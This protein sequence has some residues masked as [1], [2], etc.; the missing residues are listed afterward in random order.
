[1]TFSLQNL[2]FHYPSSQTA[3]LKN[4]TLEIGPGIHGFTGRTGS[5]K[6]TICRVL[7]RLYPVEDASLLFEGLDVN[8]LALDT[9]RSHI[10]YVAQ[11]PVLFSNTIAANIRLGAPHSSFAQV[12]QAARLAAIHDD[13][14]GLPKQYETLI[15][16]RGIKLS[17]GQRQRLALARALLV[18]RSVLLIDDGLSAVDVETEHEIF[19]RLKEHF[20]DKTVV[21]VSN[22]LKLLTM[23]DHIIILE[24]GVIANDGHHEQLLR[25]SSLYRAMYDKQMRENR[26]EHRRP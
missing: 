16:E 20:Q 5:G 8:E 1:P 22:R 2:T 23:T 25:H 13:I 7:A 6:S 15:G 26:Q 19:A 14:V 17:G 3:V 21:I 9:V 10:A 12:E 18:D 4:I 24:D 11:E